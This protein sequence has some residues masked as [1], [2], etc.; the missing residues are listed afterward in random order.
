[1]RVSTSS[2]NFQTI[3]G[4]LNSIVLTLAALCLMAGITSKYHWLV[5]G[6]KALIFFGIIS[7]F[8]KGS[9]YLITR[10]NRKI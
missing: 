4:I 1:M 5:L 7:L 6:M 8:V 9:E 10:K 2:K 3:Y